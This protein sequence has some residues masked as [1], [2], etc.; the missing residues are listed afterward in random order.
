MKKIFTLLLMLCATLGMSAASYQVWVKGVQVTDANKSDVLGDGKIAFVP[1]TSGDYLNIKAGASYSYSENFIK[2]QQDLTIHPLGKVTLESTS[3]AYSCIASMNGDYRLTISRYW[4]DIDAELILNQ[5]N[6]NSGIYIGNSAGQ[7]KLYNIKMTI[8]STSSIW[9]CIHTGSDGA[10]FYAN[11]CEITLNSSSTK[12]PIMGFGSFTLDYCGITSP[13]GAKYDTSAKVFKNGSTTVTGTVKIEPTNYQIKVGGYLVTGHNYQYIDGTSKMAYSPSSKTLTLNKATLTSPVTVYSDFEGDITLDIKGAVNI[14]SSNNPV[15]FNNNGNATITSS[16]G[17]GVLTAKSSSSECAGIRAYRNGKTLTIKDC[18]INASGYWG[19]SGYEASSSAANKLVMENAKVVAEGTDA[20]M[21]AFADITTKGCYFESTGVNNM[22]FSSSKTG[23]VSGSTLMKNVIVNKGE[24]YD[25]WYCA[26]RLSSN[27]KDNVDGNGNIKYDGTNNRF[28]I[29]DA[30]VNYTGSSPF[31]SSMNPDKPLQVY[32]TGTNNITCSGYGI[33]SRA[34]ASIYNTNGSGIGTIATLNLT[35][36]ND[37]AVNISNGKNLR[38]NG[39]TANLASSKNAIN[40]FDN[41]ITL[42]V[43][44]AVLTLKGGNSALANCKSV[45]Y[46]NVDVVTPSNGKFDASVKSFVANGEILKE[47]EIGEKAYDISVTGTQVKS[48]NKNDILG[49]G[50]VSYDSENKVL[51]V[52]NATLMTEGNIIDFREEGP[53]TI[54]LEGSNTFWSSKAYPIYYERKLD[55]TSGQRL[56]IESSTDGSLIVKG[57]SKQGIY[58]IYGGLT[59]RNCSV[60]VSGYGAGIAGAD[61]NTSSTATCVIDNANVKAS[62]S[63]YAMFYKSITLKNCY[64][65][66]PVNAVFTPSQYTFTS[67]GTACKNIE[68]KAGVSGIDGITTE[69]QNDGKIYDLRGVEVDKN[70]KGI[71]IKGGKKVMQK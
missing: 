37:Y 8:N 5:P 64:V 50:K 59:I 42:E 46:T 31:I 22:V 61:T 34:D 44:N 48:S 13:S 3:S 71:V 18:E 21:V 9:G 2:A 49:N 39:I 36:K 11:G 29:S 24:G 70:Y 54:N 53:L 68:I 30:T 7:L 62:G 10:T 14:T 15:Y 28:T 69:E 56:T 1:S 35:S 26:K 38:F 58:H 27:N 66:N 19:I 67:N 45:T 17:T 65:A 57:D 60:E 33:V 41:S 40:G 43:K 55:G 12:S 20:A 32:V 25:V 52:K 47:V 16:D 23:I 51:T 4:S 63:N 6:G